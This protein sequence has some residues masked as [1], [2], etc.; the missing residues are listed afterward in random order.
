MQIVTTLSIAIFA[1]I[2]TSTFIWFML[3]VHL[4]HS[5]FI[6]CVAAFARASDRKYDMDRAG[7]IIG[8]ASR[9]SLPWGMNVEDAALEFVEWRYQ[10]RSIHPDWI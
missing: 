10:Q 2:G 7:A 3:R 1:A 5:A 8:E 6:A 4:N 9:C